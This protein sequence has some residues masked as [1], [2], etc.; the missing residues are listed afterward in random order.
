V[1]PPLVVVGVGVGLILLTSIGFVAWRG[2]R[3]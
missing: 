2:Q 3:R 1:D